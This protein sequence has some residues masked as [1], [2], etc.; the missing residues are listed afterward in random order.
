[1]PKGPSVASKPKIVLYTG[2][3]EIQG[4]RAHCPVPDANLVWLEA[5][6]LERG[7]IDSIKYWK[8]PDG[9]N[10]VIDG[11]S[12]LDICERFTID[13]D[14]QELK[15]DSRL[16]AIN[17]F[18]DS[19]VARRNLT[20]MQKAYLNG[21]RYN[22]EKQL[23]GGDRRSIAWKASGHSGRLKTQTEIADEEE[24][25]ARTL[26][27]YAEF[28]KGI[29]NLSQVKGPELAKKVLSEQIKFSMKDIE[30]LGKMTPEM[31]EEELD[32]KDAK[33]EKKT[34]SKDDLFAEFDKIL[35]SGWKKLKEVD[36]ITEESNKTKLANALKTASAIAEMLKKIQENSET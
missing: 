13:Y 3:E 32:R 1:M 17:Y 12:R 25:S 2:D 7:C 18:I 31:V 26:R 36:K 9:K 21:R 14:T 23:H 29:D 20:E 15:F 24:L 28:A 33:P 30:K 5:D 16:E 11:Y 6:I 22:V 34:L 10:I 19:Q 4:L 8:S 27:R 35:Q